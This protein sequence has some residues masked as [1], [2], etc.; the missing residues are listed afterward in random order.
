MIISKIKTK[1]FVYYNLHAEQVMISSY[2]ND[3]NGFLGI[4][5][6]LLVSDTIEKVLKDVK[7]FENKN[8]VLDFNHINNISQNNI[9]KKF[10]DFI[11]CD[12]KFVFININKDIIDNLG[13]G[14]YSNKNDDFD[15]FIYK[16]ICLFK[17]DLEIFREKI[18]PNKLFRQNFEDTIANYI[19]PY[20]Q[21]H[22]SSY[23]YLYSYVDLK[24]FIT[25]EKQLFLFSMYRLA[26]KIRNRCSQELE[27]KPILVCQSLNSSLIASILSNLLNLDILILDKIGPINKLY[28]RLDKTISENKKYIIVSD[29]VCLGTEVKIVKNLIQFLGG[30]YLKN[31]SLIKIETLNSEDIDKIDKKDLTIA[32]FSI[33]KSNN[34]KLKY[35][36]TTNLEDF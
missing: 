26:N 34:A 31:A 19:I 1:K 29:L 14:G 7:D 11:N 3:T 30:V 21:P 28:S 33:N 22:S 8:I 15:E 6:D 20:N 18:N 23:I 10:Y 24:D 25:N 5:E 16:K 12:Y 36:I 4:Y 27:K 13:F 35:K 2:Y 9:N 17:E 32:V